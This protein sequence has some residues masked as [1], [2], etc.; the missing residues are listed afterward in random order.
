MSSSTHQSVTTQQC[1]GKWEQRPGGS[2]RVS[3]AG[4]RSDSSTT[5]LSRGGRWYFL[6]K[7]GTGALHLGI[8][9]LCFRALQRS[10]PCPVTGSQTITTRPNCTFKQLLLMQECYV[11]VTRPEVSFLLLA[12]FSSMLTDK[13]WGISNTFIMTFYHGCFL[14]D[15]PSLTVHLAFMAAITEM[16]AIHLQSPS[17]LQDGQD[18]EVFGRQG[19]SVSSGDP[20]LLQQFSLCWN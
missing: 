1:W 11:R 15:I 4:R 8:P 19:D 16:S 13:L 3:V 6:C 5:V 20:C 9:A 12:L 17:L 18:A 2:T 14:Q 7:V 10:V